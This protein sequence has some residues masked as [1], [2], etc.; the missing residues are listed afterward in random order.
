M[1]AAGAFAPINF[2]QRVH[3]TRPDEELS[4]KDLY[5]SLKMSFLVQKMLHNFE[6]LGCGITLLP[7]KN[8]MHP[9]CQVLG[10]APASK[11]G[12]TSKSLKS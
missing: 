4:Y 2:Q 10:A 5:F 7:L 12:F 11:G 6:F 1:G 3:C 9:S 8:F